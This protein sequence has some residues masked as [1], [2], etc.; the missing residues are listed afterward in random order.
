MAKNDDLQKSFSRQAKAGDAY[1]ETKSLQ[2][3]NK[4]EWE[5]LCDGCAKCCLHKFIEDDG[6]EEQT[7]TDVIH[8]GEQVVV[9]KIAC[10]Y[11]NDKTCACTQYE[12]RTELVPDCVKLTKS[13]LESVF[14][15]PPSCAYRRLSEGKP[16][17]SW[18]PLLN[19]GRKSAMHRAGMS[20]RGKVVHDDGVNIHKFEDFIVTWPLNIIE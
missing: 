2:E 8:E 10:E 1:W 11:L 9:T 4:D 16:L 18:H 19:G 14:F 20:V 3:M 6:F 5:A 7:P 12:K 15:M 13:N 17:P